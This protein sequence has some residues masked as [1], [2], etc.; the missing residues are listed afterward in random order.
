MD[1]GYKVLLVDDE[2]EIREGMA[3]RIPWEELG[4]TICGTAENGLEALDIIEKE[5]PEIII[6]DIQMPFM[7]GLELI[8]Q[9]RLLLP[10]SKF[11]VFSGYDVF[12]YAQKAVSL[13]V[14]EYLL[15]P[16]SAQDLIEVLEKVKASMDE[17]K[18]AQR[19]IEKLQQQFEESL[20]LL[21]Q[22]FLLSCL[23]GGMTP[24]SI[25]QQ[26]SRLDLDKNQGYSVLLFD[27]GSLQDAPHFQGKEELYLVAV[28]QFILENLSPVVQS[29]TFIFGEVIISI[30]LLEST[31]DMNELLKRINEICREASRLNGGTVV[32]GVSQR[33][34]TLFQLAFAYE[35]AQ[36]ALA[37]SYRLDRQ[38]WFTT[39]IQDVVQQSVAL[40]ILTEQEQRRFANLLKLGSREGLETFVMD[41]FEKISDA[42]LSL[43]QYRVYLLEHVTLLLRIMN[44]YEMTPMSIFQE[45]VMGKIE[46]LDKVSLEEMRDWFLQKS[47][48]LRQGIQMTTADSGK[49]LIQKAKLLVKENYQNPDLTIEEISQKLYLSAAYFSSVFKKETGQS[50]VSYLTKERLSQAVI[51][52]ETTADKSYMIAAKVGYSEPNYFSYVFKKHYGLSPSKYRNQLAQSS[53]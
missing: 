16:F 23:N 48:Q 12:E 34:A 22:S 43:P 32:A 39:Y 36:D 21:R 45:D 2:A 27:G 14:A 30:L 10:L 3:H 47:E 13:H 24:E 6:T 28:K 25:V 19:D 33:V 40:F 15:K 7:D 4:F 31:I 51:L 26:S 46:Q 20:P 5:Y 9:A 11:I 1:K 52:L 38:E 41:T 8:E 50:F 49:A 29:E 44:S 17:E 42:H 37:Y 35:Q 53:R 18:Q